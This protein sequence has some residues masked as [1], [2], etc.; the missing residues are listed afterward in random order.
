MWC[1]TVPGLHSQEELHQ[2]EFLHLQGS[3]L[4]CGGGQTPPL[5]P[6][7]SSLFLHWR[8]S[9]FISLHGSYYCLSGC[10][11]DFSAMLT[12]ANDD[13]QYT[14]VS[15]TFTSTETNN[16]SFIS[17]EEQEGRT[18]KRWE[19][20]LHVYCRPHPDSNLRSNLTPGKNWKGLDRFPAVILL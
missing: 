5:L 1:A 4:L 9:S 10:A 13:I 8:C 2:G 19:K 20:V 12:N 6:H 17:S 11:C 3:P 7:L 15:W 14:E 18:K 16:N